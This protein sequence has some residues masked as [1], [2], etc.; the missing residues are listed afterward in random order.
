M[1][2]GFSHFRRRRLGVTETTIERAC[3]RPIDRDHDLIDRAELLQWIRRDRDA[4]DSISSGL[5]SHSSS[6]EGYSRGHG[7]TNWPH[8]PRADACA[9]PSSSSALES[10]SASDIATSS[11]SLDEEEL[12]EG[13][14]PPPS[15]ASA[16]CSA[17]ASG[18]ASAARTL[19]SAASPPATT[20]SAGCCAP[21]CGTTSP[22][23]GT[24]IDGTL[25][26]L[27]PSEWPA[28]QW[29]RVRALEHQCQ[30]TGIATPVMTSASK[31]YPAGCPV[32]CPAGCPGGSPVGSPASGPLVVPWLSVP[33]VVP[34]LSCGLCRGCTH[35]PMSSDSPWIQDRSR[36]Y[37][38]LQEVRVA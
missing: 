20:P 12:D 36:G 30:R 21:D 34:R 33:R 9:W 35:V 1:S 25:G 13:A 37:A 2:S 5:A 32:R 7:Q 4:S 26:A 23:A 28:R 11:S 10:P 18:G 31:G 22:T 3:D 16:G 15:A 27:A 19:S 24:P 38:R 17:A 6:C 29:T 8:R 14:S